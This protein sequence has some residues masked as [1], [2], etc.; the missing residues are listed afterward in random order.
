VTPAVVI[1]PG[2]GTYNAAELGYFTRHHADKADF[3]ADIDALR[4]A[5]DETPVSELDGAPAFKASVHGRGDNASP[6]IFACSFADFLAIE[7][8]RFEIVAVTGNSMGWYTALGCAGALDPMAALDLVD[9]MGG[10]MQAASIGGQ[11]IWSLVDED[12]RE[13]PGR[14]AELL[15]AREAIR[16]HDGAELHVSIELG[17]M[18]VMAGNRAGLE[19]MAHLAPKGPGRFPV[20]LAGH[21]GFHSPLQAP[22]SERAR[23]TIDPGAFRQ[24]K[25]PLIDGSGRIWRPHATDVET[26][27]DYTIGEQLTETYDFTRAV[28]VSVKEFAPAA[29]IVLGPG[30]TLGGAVAQSLIAIAWKGLNSKAD[31]QALQSASPFV[32]AMGRDDQRARVTG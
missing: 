16:G 9:T 18:L 24:P 26:L 22:V 13:I 11:A 15:A 14:R 17:G 6:L 10:L 5:R 23:G 2:R 20:T 4:A 28:Q 1:C 29:L 27:W 21:A 19:A 32:L 31:F 8:A 12:W 3:L 30:E 7:R 25:V